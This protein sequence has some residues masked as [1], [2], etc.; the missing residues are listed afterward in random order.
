MDTDSN[1]TPM[2][3]HCDIH[4]D[5]V[6]AVVCRHHVETSDHVVGFV[7]NSDDPGDLQAWC[8]A[9]EELFIREGDKTKR[10]VRFN[11]FAIVCVRCYA[12]LKARHSG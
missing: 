10:F 1:D 6:A 3:V 7:E 12:Q 2:T 8:D 9:C 5:D 11:N 4:G